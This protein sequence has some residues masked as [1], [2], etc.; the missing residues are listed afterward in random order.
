[1]RVLSQGEIDNL[2]S[3]LLKDSSV[4]PET[5]AAAVSAAS[6]AFSDS[7][8]DTQPEMTMFERLLAKSKEINN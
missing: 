1:M 4:L 2:L 8:A 7:S 5:G 3:G 6:P